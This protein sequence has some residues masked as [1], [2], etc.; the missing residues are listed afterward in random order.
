MGKYKKAYKTCEKAFKKGYVDI[1]LLNM[2]AQALDG[3]YEH[4]AAIKVCDEAM[5]SGS[6]Q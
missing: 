1:Q 5:A 3:M 4:E 6:I 2:K